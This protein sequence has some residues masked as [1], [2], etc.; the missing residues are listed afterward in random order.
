MLTCS[1]I[2]IISPWEI[3]SPGFQL[4]FA[5]TAG[6]LIFY[7]QYRR[8]LETLPSIIADTTAVTLSAQIITLPIILFHMKQLNTAGILSNI[9][10]IPLISLIMGIA[11]FTILFS[12]F[13][14]FVAFFLASLTD[15]LLKLSLLI[16]T[17][18]SDLRLNFYVYDITPSLCIL[19]LISIIPLINYRK[20]IQLKFYPVILSAILCTLYLKKNYQYDGNSY[21]IST[22]SSKAEIRIEDK[23]QI[24]KLDLK[25]GVDSEKILS[26]IMM[27][28]PDIKIVEL[29]DNSSPNLIVSKKI[30]NDFILQ[31]YRF[32][33]IP[34][35]N[36]MIKK[37]IFQLEKDNVIVKFIKKSSLDEY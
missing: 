26:G 15:L 34:D 7:K 37:I 9:I 29:A 12:F 14:F 21:I 28:N 30:I 25:E 1:I 35:L 33:G 4:S 32:T 6:I 2:L 24:L 13:S 10:I 3:F 20:I 31:E 5:A 17:F 18:I 23:K 11:L 27:K 16:T 19:I 36:N 8:S 22:G